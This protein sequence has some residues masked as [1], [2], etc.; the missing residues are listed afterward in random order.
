MFSHVI[1]GETKENRPALV[2]RFGTKSKVNW[3][4]LPSSLPTAETSR[5]YGPSQSYC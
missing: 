1:G 2:I 5:L 3:L 4:P